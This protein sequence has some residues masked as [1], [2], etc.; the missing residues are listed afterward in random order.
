MKN[1]FFSRLGLG[2]ALAALCS[3]T[4]SATSRPEWFGAEPITLNVNAKDIG[5]SSLL[6][7]QQ[8]GASLCAISYNSFMGRET[9]HLFRGTKTAGRSELVKVRRIRGDMNESPKMELYS[10]VTGI[11]Q[12][13]YIG[14]DEDPRLF[15]LQGITLPLEMRQA[16]ELLSECAK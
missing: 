2:L 11:V 3:T 6:G 1:A 15:F 10:G 4:A 14:Q 7:V 12:R 16:V 9:A 13:L 8:D 5:Y